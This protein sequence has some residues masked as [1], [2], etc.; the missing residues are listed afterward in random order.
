MERGNH[1]RMSNDKDFYDS[2]CEIEKGFIKAKL[3]YLP[4]VFI[5]K[6]DGKMQVIV[7]IFH[8]T[9]EKRMYQA[10]IKK[11]CA[12]QDTDFYITCFDVKMTMY[13]KDDKNLSN[14]K[15]KDALLINKYSANDKIMSVFP[16]DNK[17]R[18]FENFDRITGRNKDVEERDEW[19]LWGKSFDEKDEALM[20]K[21]DEFKAKNKDMFK[22][23][24]K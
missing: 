15:V 8:N 11:F 21:Y 23:V 19:D 13:D 4:K 10:L 9:D 6:R 17:T 2:V 3:N 20:K 18:E 16:Y 7:L 5:H 14:A 24:N 12:M 1:N 22:E